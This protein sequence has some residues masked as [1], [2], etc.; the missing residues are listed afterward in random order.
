MKLLL[1]ILL[2][3]Y[4]VGI[5]GYAALEMVQDK[6]TAEYNGLVQNCMAKNKFQNLKPITYGEFHEL[7]RSDHKKVKLMR[8]SEKHFFTISIAGGAIGTEAA[9]YYLNHK[10]AKPGFIYNIPVHIAINVL[11]FGFLYYV[12]RNRKK[13]TVEDYDIT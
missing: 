11:I 8:T 9:M 1:R 3:I 5:N 10:T 4:F 2:I 12:L 13:K 6:R 7:S